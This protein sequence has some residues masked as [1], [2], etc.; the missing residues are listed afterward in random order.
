ME[1]ETALGLV[2]NGATLL[3]LD[4][5]QFTLIGIDTLVISKRIISLLRKFGKIKIF[6]V[7]VDQSLG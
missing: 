4:M 5:P 6:I 2:R 7:P 1:P 3:L